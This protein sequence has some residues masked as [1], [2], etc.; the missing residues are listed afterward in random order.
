MC[1]TPLRQGYE[2]AYHPLELTFKAPMWN[3]LGTLGCFIHGR[4]VQRPLFHP[5]N[6]I[7]NLSL[8]RN[9]QPLRN[10]LGKAIPGY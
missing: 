5:D 10:E 8:Q 2:N 4:C 3:N 1:S 7:G 6:V 9:K